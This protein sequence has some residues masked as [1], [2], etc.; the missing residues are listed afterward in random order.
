MVLLVLAA[1][2]AIVALAL[3]IVNAVFKKNGLTIAVFTLVIIA[4][5]LT[6]L[7]LFL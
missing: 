5:I 6:L 4:V 1:L 3:V 2:L 7:F